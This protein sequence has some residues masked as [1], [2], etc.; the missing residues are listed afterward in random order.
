[1]K[2]ILSEKYLLEETNLLCEAD[3][4]FSLGGNDKDYT[5]ATASV[6]SLEKLRQDLETFSNNFLNATGDGFALNTVE[7]KDIDD[8]Y[9][10]FGTEL[11]NLQNAI[12]NTLNRIED[13]RETKGGKL[14]DSTITSNKELTRLFNELDVD[15]KNTKL[16]VKINSTNIDQ[17]I[18]S[19]EK[20]IN[21][22]TNT[23]NSILRVIDF[24]T[25]EEEKNNKLDVK[26]KW[27]EYLAQAK[28]EGHLNEAWEYYLDTKWKDDK[29]KIK[30]L[31][32]A[33][34]IEVMNYGDA[35]SPA[36]NNVNPF[37]NFIN[38][39]KS[40]GMLNLLNEGNYGHIHNALV[41][42]YLTDA[43]INGEGKLRFGEI[44]N[45][46]I[47]KENFYKYKGK[48]LDVLLEAQFDVIRSLLSIET[49]T[50]QKNALACLYTDFTEDDSLDKVP[51][52]IT[53]PES[54]SSKLKAYGV[55]TKQEM[56]K[57]E[58]T[59]FVNR[60][61]DP[62]YNT[63]TK[64]SLGVSSEKEVATIAINCIIDSDTG[65]KKRNIQ[66]LFNDYIQDSSI[67]DLSK[68]NTPATLD[69]T[70][71]E[72]KRVIERLIGPYTNKTDTNLELIGAMLTKLGLKKKETEKK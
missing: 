41:T 30:S 60:L 9:K 51:M 39:F 55:E 22:T 66:Q 36:G 10:P 40:K 64:A 31:G 4:D 38:Y 28:R 61:L 19:V 35:K 20:N 12:T 46:I 23:L 63:D 2:Y 18:S 58:M 53:P 11:D 7:L 54:I 45:N 52:I 21:T 59:R 65:L 29:E 72:Q 25:D 44:I 47:Y 16:N 56:G 32:K 62:E 57:G 5:I 48:Q 67:F 14:A 69:E 6:Q 71:L 8:K 42:G 1:M 24:T 68:I 26:N 15:L 50:N 43:D 49:E 27:Q 13:D 17:V 33:F 3:N 70:T 34:K 37:I